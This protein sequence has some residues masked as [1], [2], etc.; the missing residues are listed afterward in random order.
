[1]AIESSALIGGRVRSREIVRTNELYI[2][3]ANVSNQGK[4]EIF[5]PSQL[6]VG[7]IIFWYFAPFHEARARMRLGQDSFR[8][9]FLVSDYIFGTPVI[10]VPASLYRGGDRPM[11]DC[12][13]NPMKFRPLHDRVV[14]RRAEGEL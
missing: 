7:V 9:Y 13:K 6:Y 1:M 5:P 11:R 3:A 4:A 8:E 12:R 10:R 2:Y 14:I